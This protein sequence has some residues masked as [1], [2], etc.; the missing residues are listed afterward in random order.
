M[1]KADVYKGDKLIHSVTYQCQTAEE[2]KISVINSMYW[3]VI[4]CAEAGEPKWWT[5]YKYKVSAV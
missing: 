3:N 1:Y 4:T 2:A 5:K